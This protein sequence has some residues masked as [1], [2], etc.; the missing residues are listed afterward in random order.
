MN[1]KRKLKKERFKIG[2]ANPTKRLNLSENYDV[3]TQKIGR[4]RRVG[5]SEDVI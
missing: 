1:I 2:D 3:E 4:G 5:R